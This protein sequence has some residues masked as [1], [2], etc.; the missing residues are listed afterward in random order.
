MFSTIST[1]ITTLFWHRAEGF[2]LSIPSVWQQ[3]RVEAALCLRICRDLKGGGRK[4]WTS[5]SFGSIDIV[6]LPKTIVPVPSGKRSHT[7]RTSA[8]ADQDFLQVPNLQV[9]ESA[10]DCPSASHVHS[11]M[12]PFGPS[13]RSEIAAATVTVAVRHFKPAGLTAGEQFRTCNPGPPGG[14]R[15][16]GG[17]WP[18][19]IGIPLMTLHTPHASTRLPGSSSPPRLRGCT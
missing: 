2:P 13:S 18:I 6:P 9:V 14:R 15:R 16:P 1:N 4:D 17:G 5:S 11:K 10:A 19:R 8:I 12:V 3:N 7:I